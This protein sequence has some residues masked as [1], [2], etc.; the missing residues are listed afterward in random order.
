M[1]RPDALSRP[2]P[3]DW[4]TMDLGYVA[5]CDP[6][7]NASSVLPAGTHLAQLTPDLYEIER[8]VAQ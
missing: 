8:P 7:A 2:I 4:L 6:G 5:L 3:S 1:L